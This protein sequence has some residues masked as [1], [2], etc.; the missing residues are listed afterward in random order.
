MR[1]L[2]ILAKWLAG[3][4]DIDVM[5]YVGITACISI[6][7][8]RRVIKIPSHWS[9]SNDPMAAELLEGVVDHEALGHGRFT[10]LEGRQKAEEA[11]LIKFNNLSAGIQN[12]LEDVYIENEAIK[13][14]P[15][16]KAN[17]AKTV[18]ILT[19]RGFF[20]S[21]DKFAM[22]ESS[23]LLR[24]G[25]L[26][27]LRCRLVPG[28][29]DA[30]KEN[31]EALEM[32]LPVMLGKLWEE[33]LAVAMEVQNS[34]STADNIDLTIRIM[35]LIEDA[36][37]QEPQ[38]QPGDDGEKSD[39]P[40]EAGGDQTSD[41]QSDSDQSSGEQGQ[42]ASGDQPDEEQ[43]DD[44]DGQDSKGQGG[45]DQ[46]SDGE[47]SSCKG[48]DS[49]D[50]SGEPMQGEG[51]GG[52]PSK[53]E[54]KKGPTQFSENEIQAAK[55][56]L[57]SQDDEMPQTEIGEAISEEIQKTAEAGPLSS[58]TTSEMKTK[59]S[60][61]SMRVCSQVKSISDEL[62]DA[63]VAETRCEKSTK[64]VGKSLNNRVL[65]RV[66]LG[67]ARVFRQK[68]EGIGLS[69]AVSI[70][71]DMSSSMTEQMAD[72]VS[73]LDGAVGLVYGLGDILDEFDVPFE[74]NAYSST[75]ATMK[76]FG[77]DWTQV[78][79]RKE[80]PF[81]SGSTY[82][83]I[84]MQKALSDLVVR[85]EDRRLMIVVTDGD[86]SD[87]DVL[88]SCYSEAQLMGIEIA[89]VMIGPKIPSIEALASRFG[90]KASNINK[91]TGLGRFA[92]DRVLESI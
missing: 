86:T 15:G 55:D 71:F 78:R 3:R 43:G 74:V 88:I 49:E 77:E 91:S 53:T 56:I 66:K 59:V 29:A 25:L 14:Y 18:E 17:L 67:N 81:I 68:L 1:N 46:P 19:K 54:P 16:V 80:R 27:I 48:G 23:S 9:Y 65:S 37:K 35:K 82:T 30:L 13:T 72:Q 5:E 31:V 10:D 24:A 84:A 83:G 26:N 57:E 50:D 11:G 76:A 32:I 73:R 61:L 90:F 64:L 21:P 36:S 42:S 33:V 7:N 41:E 44:Q 4:V 58:M 34:T 62:Q 47:P 12:I 2:M 6:Y 52:Q 69:T 51:S 38:P 70:L 60:D 45:G 85:Q 8:G 20:G 87:L 63:L 39:E 40:N 79:K 89:S 22:G 75:F 92:V 28:Q